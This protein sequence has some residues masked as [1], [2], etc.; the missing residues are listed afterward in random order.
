M[1]SLADYTSFISF[2]VMRTDAYVRALRNVIRPG[3]LCLDIG[4]GTGFFAV[5]ACH[6]GAR[7]VI[8]IEPDDA[9]HVARDVALA[10]GCAERITFIQDLSTRVQLEERADVIV[11]D[12]RGILPLFG[13]HLPSIM[14]AR[15]RLLAPQGMLIPQRDFLWAAPVEAPDAYAR[16]VPLTEDAV[17]GV[18]LEPTRLRLVN[19]WDKARLEPEQLLAAPLQWACLDYTQ[20][21]SA[22]VRGEA[23]WTVARAGTC[24]GLLLWFDTMLV[25][26][27]GFSNAPGQPKDLY[28]QAFFPWAHPVPLQVGDSVAVSLRAD[29]VGGDYIWSW[30]SRV[31][32]G[33]PTQPVKADFHQ[34]TFFGAGLNTGPLRKRGDSHQIKLNEDGQIDHFIL[35]Q[36]NGT[37]TVG[38][39]ARQV[40]AQF[41]HQF[42]TWA[43]AL[44]R[45][46]DIAVK[47]SI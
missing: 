40:A 2:A 35:C 30:D 27:V 12:L 7:K 37:A 33:A 20:L 14:D 39:I 43:D 11:S 10:N 18:T 25:E 44:P 3:C 47:Y 8:A 5:L 6:F 16:I 38:D 29:L 1:H 46:G 15:R 17:H 32:P 28:G 41:P 26:S 4:T 31:R 22:N 23:A 13:R 36:V 45:V 34:S 9:I 24:Y 19:H 42:P 21:E